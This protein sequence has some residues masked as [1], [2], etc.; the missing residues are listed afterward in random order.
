MIQADTD[1]FF[2]AFVRLTENSIFS[3]S[4]QI[5]YSIE[6]FDILI[7]T[8]KPDCHIENSSRLDLCG[9]KNYQSDF[10]YFHG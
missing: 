6:I 8:Q 1:I 2:D 3:L 10:W 4:I 5:S 7:K 9:N